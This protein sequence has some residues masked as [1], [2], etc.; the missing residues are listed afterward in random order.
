MLHPSFTEIK[1]NV[2]D[3]RKDSPELK[4]RYTLVIAA[5]NRA[6]QLNEGADPMVD[7]EPNQK[8]LSIAVN[9]INAGLIHLVDEDKPVVDDKMAIQYE[10]E[11]SG[12]ENMSEEQ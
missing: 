1:Q 12:Q 8:K 6:R 11:F 2:N 10:K 7:S 4:I 5:A 9:E 3:T